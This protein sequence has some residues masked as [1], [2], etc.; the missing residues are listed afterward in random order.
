[1]NFGLISPIITVS[2]ILASSWGCVYFSLRL[3]GW[4]QRGRLVNALLIWT[5]WFAVVC[6]LYIGFRL[7]SGPIR[8]DWSMSRI[9]L[10]FVYLLVVGLAGLFS[11]FVTTRL[12]QRHQ[13]D[14]GANPFD[15]VE[16][17]N[18]GNA[19]LYRAFFIN[20]AAIIGFGASLASAMIIDDLYY[21]RFSEPEQK[22]SFAIYD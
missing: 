10:E 15:Y 12:L 6:S 9:F 13:Q 2:T 5:V 19:T 3:L 8:Y 11:I 22:T 16:V 21:N 7:L 17:S 14:E 18:S 1:M 20:L 4:K